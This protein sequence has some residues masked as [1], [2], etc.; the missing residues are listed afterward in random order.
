MMYKKRYLK[1]ETKN[2]VMYK[3]KSTNKKKYLRKKNISLKR[4]QS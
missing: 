1:K 3:R 2:N 4:K